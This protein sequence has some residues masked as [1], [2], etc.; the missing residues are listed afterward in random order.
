MFSLSIPIKQI[1]AKTYLSYHKFTADHRGKHKIARIL[2]SCLGPFALKTAEGPM[3]N[4]FLGSPMDISYFTQV[5][6]AHRT[7]IDM[8]DSLNHGDTFIDIG[9][10]IGFY[11]ILASSKVGTAGK[12]FCF[13]PSSREYRRLLDAVEMNL[14]EN[15]IPYNVALSDHCGIARMCIDRVHT[16]I[17]KLI[18]KTLG[19]HDYVLS[20]VTTL[21]SA[22]NYVKNQTVKLIKIDV[23]GAEYSV[24]LGMADFLSRND[25]RSLVIEITPKFLS[26]YG[27]AKEMIY[28]FMSNHGYIATVKSE[29]WQY[30][31]Y[32]IR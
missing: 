21:D 24:L 31:E 12:V 17:N 30:D 27:H 20:P 1:I 14:S 15:I 23:E 16:G 22:L 2:D 8:I 18:H 7:I 28:E 19:T 5:E 10:N 25:V 6:A 11:S 26:Q 9:T 3:L 4:I 29:E 13:E 32:F